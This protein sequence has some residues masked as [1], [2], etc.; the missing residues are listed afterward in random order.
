MQRLA[1]VLAAAVL[2]AV[3]WI[4]IVLCDETQARDAREDA[5]A[6]AGNLATAVAW[7]L[8]QQLASLGQT[9]H[10]LAGRWQDDP[11]HFDAA[12]AR[13]LLL[14]EFGEQVI[15]LDPQGRVTAT[16]IPALGGL[17]LRNRPFFRVAQAAPPGGL[18]F[19][20]TVA[21]GPG[22][23]A[24]IHLARRLPDARGN[25]AAVLVVTLDPAPLASAIQGMT[26]GPDAMLGLIG[27]GTDLHRL[28]GG[29]DGSPDG[30]I[31]GTEMLSAAETMPN[32]DWQGPSAL[33]GRERIHAFR[34]LN[35]REPQV[36]VAVDVAE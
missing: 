8:H 24:L 35:P 28:V 33:D 12:A 26:L 17:D 22:R 27:P 30:A 10:I 6:N 2:V 32:G 34:R 3:L 15:V 23:K 7:Q 21:T 5:A 25:L 11:D 4:A 14:P 18:Y 29:R 31:D 36:V 13:S 19:G 20:P 1:V 9:I 16:T